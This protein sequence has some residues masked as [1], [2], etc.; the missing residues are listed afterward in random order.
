MVSHLYNHHG[1]QCLKLEH[2]LEFKPD[3][4]YFLFRTI[5]LPEY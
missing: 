1:E 3:M 4:S 5:D 2:P